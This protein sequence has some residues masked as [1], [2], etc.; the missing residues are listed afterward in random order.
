MKN[1]HYSILLLK[2]DQ[3]ALAKQIDRDRRLILWDQEAIHFLKFQW[4]NI[5]NIL[6]FNNHTID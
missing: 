3:N 6:N 1:R 4:L 5:K 2:I